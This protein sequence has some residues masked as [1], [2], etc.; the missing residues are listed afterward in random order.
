MY[1]RLWLILGLAAAG[2]VMHS[3]LPELGRVP[4]FL[5]TAEDG[6]SVTRDS[7]RG[8]VWVVDFIFTNCQGPCPRLSAQVHRLEQRLMSKG[9]PPEDVRLISITVDPDR[10]TPAVLAA[11]AR[12]FQADPR[13]WHFLT[14][15]A[16]AV[17]ALSADT[18]HVNVSS[19]LLEHSTKLILVDKKARIRGY[20]ESLDASALDQLTADIG[21]LRK[22][23]L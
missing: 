9:Q 7:L 20:Y 17:G 15:P 8:K 10:D 22:E 16:G 3:S 13:V 2:C 21:Q 19:N 4:P 5:L 23:I 11:Y 1:R 14:G 6:T 12:N 18:F